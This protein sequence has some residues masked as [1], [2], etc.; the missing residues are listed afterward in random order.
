M[1]VRVKSCIDNCV[2]AVLV[3]AIISGC[4]EPADQT[5]ESAELLRGSSRLSDLL[6]DSDREGYAMAT[7]PREFRFP[8][9]HGPHPDFR[10]EWWYVTGNLDG[11]GG[12]RFGYEL[13]FFRFSLTP[14]SVV[15]VESSWRTNQV[16]VAHFA[17]SDIHNDQFHV[18]QRYS[19]GSLGLA[20]A[21]AKPFR[22]WVDDWMIEEDSA[23]EG[24][25]LRAK[26]DGFG[27]ELQLVAEKEPVLNGDRGLSQK[28]DKQGNASFYYSIPRL[29][30]DG[31]ASLA[32]KTYTVSGA[33]WLDREWS[34]SALSKDQVGWDWFAL[35]L[36]DGSDLMFYQL[37]RNDGTIDAYSAGTWV[38]AGG[39]S[40]RLGHDDVSISV[41]DYWQSERG[42]EYPA[43]WTISIPSLNIALDVT[44]AIADQELITNVRYWEGA[45]D[46][47]GNSGGESISGRG[48]VELTGYAEN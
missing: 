5:G 8:E 13:T 35:Q 46:V 45:V 26:G 31:T 30:S 3:S 40:T 14:N 33:S 44:P 47:A 16:Y 42:G 7:E 23:S 9:D 48:Y 39:D 19:R 6:G 29:R 17:I 20:G 11:Q 32:G 38:Q 12:E 15:A 22:V 1:S 24:W 36:S 27:V 10:N 2:F 37:R 43:G 25:Q 41:T 21:I 28:S 4:G 18:A 34:S